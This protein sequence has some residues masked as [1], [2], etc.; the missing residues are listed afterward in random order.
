MH[1]CRVELCGRCDC[2]H[3]P[4]GVTYK[5]AAGPGRPRPTLFPRTGGKGLRREMTQI[6]QKGRLS[7]Q[8]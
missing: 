5:V 1:P 8:K 7:I 3:L 6:C 2:P 4:T